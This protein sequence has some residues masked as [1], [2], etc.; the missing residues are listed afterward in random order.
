MDWN[1]LTWENIKFYTYTQIKVGTA[2][3]LLFYRFYFPPTFVGYT[4][5]KII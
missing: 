1:E 2:L 4:V 5:F 3:L